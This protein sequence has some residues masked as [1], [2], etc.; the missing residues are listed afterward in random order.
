M[1]SCYNTSR[2]SLR[3]T[4]CHPLIWPISHLIPP[5][6]QHPS[7]LTFHHRFLP[8]FKII[9][10]GTGTLQVTYP[11]A[12]H[13]HYHQTTNMRSLSQIHPL[14]PVNIKV[15]NPPTIHPHPQSYHTS[16]PHKIHLIRL[17]LIL[18][19]QQ[20]W[21]CLHLQCNTLHFYIKNKYFIQLILLSNSQWITLSRPYTL[22]FATN[23]TLKGATW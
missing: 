19:H 14:P 1:V 23:R 10:T 6:F 21:F 4:T 20:V 9:P 2:A 22:K 11:Q 7:Q 15:L 18:H 17:A 8:Q 5:V 12:F 16:Q 3:T 13:L